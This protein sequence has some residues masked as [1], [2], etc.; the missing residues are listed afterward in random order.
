MLC[1][2]A[3][4][5][6]R[7]SVSGSESGE[8]C[9]KHPAEPENH[10]W[11][12]AGRFVACGQRCR[13]ASHSHA[14]PAKAPLTYARISYAG[15]HHPNA[16]TQMPPCWRTPTQKN[17]QTSPPLSRAA[18]RRWSPAGE[19]C[20]GVPYVVDQADSSA[21]SA[22]ASLQPSCSIKVSRKTSSLPK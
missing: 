12:G 7:P 10:E 9:Y 18:W 17:A 20:T 11:S 6:P 21:V 5:P 3:S 1:I 13:T 14:S 2:C 8:F 4:S 16:L 15:P 19:A 22:A